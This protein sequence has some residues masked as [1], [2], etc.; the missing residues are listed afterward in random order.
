MLELQPTSSQQNPALAHV[1]DNQIDTQ[2]RS[3]ENAPEFKFLHEKAVGEDE[4]AA[5]LD[6]MWARLK[7]TVADKGKGQ[8]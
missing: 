4:I 6:D 2:L 8:P 5:A 1:R 3:L 7:C